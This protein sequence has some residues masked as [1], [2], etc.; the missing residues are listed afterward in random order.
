MKNREAAAMECEG[1]CLYRT[2]EVGSKDGHESVVAPSFTEF[3]CELTTSLGEPSVVPSC[4][5]SD[6]VVL[7]PRMRFEN[8]FDVAGH[9][10]TLPVPGATRK[11]RMC[12]DHPDGG[13]GAR[14]LRGFVAFGGTVRDEHVAHAA[15]ACEGLWFRHGRLRPAV[16]HTA[17]VA[18]VRGSGSGCR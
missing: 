15:R 4:R 2:S 6:V 17:E 7:T 13:W 5:A 12:T 11:Q 10:R 1:R 14:T 3:S 9:K 16:G 8:D 18:D